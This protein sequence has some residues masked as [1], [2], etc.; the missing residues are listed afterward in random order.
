AGK[1]ILELDDP[2][3]NHPS[4]VALSRSL[5]AATPLPH[6]LKNGSAF[7][8]SAPTPAAADLAAIEE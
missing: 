2:P 4:A 5:C 3:R 7:A 8:A 6:L 1:T